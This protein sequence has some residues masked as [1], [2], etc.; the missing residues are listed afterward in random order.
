LRV[1]NAYKIARQFF[2]STCTA[3][4]ENRDQPRSAAL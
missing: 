2:R 4:L 1:N 3:F